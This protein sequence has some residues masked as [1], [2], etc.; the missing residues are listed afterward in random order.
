[1]AGS[2]SWAPQEHDETLAERDVEVR[3][4]A[5][6]AAALHDAARERPGDVA[7]PPFSHLGVRSC[8]SLRDGAIRPR[9]LAA[10]AAAAGMTHVALTDRD[11]LY[12]AVRFAQAAAAE[13]VTPVFG[14]DLALAPDAARPGWELS[15]AGRVRL[16]A[17]AARRSTVRSPAG[18]PRRARPGRGAAWLEDDAP[19]VTFLARTTQ[20]YG[21]LCAT[22]TAAHAFGRSDPH[23]PAEALATAASRDGV[24]ALLGVDSPVGR[25][26]ARGHLDAAEA[27]VRRWLEVFG[28][29]GVVLGVRDHRVAPGGRRVTGGRTGHDP[30]EPG[31]DVRIRR[32]L[33]LAARLQVRAAAVNDVRYLRPEDVAVAD[34]LRCIRQQVPLGRRH[35]GRTTADAWFTTPAEQHDRFRERPDLLTTAHELATACEVDLGVGGLHVPRLSGLSPEAAAGELHRRCWEGVA[36]RYDRITPRIRERLERELAMVDR[37]ALHDL[38]LAVAAVV[39]DI[40]ELGV[41]VACRGSAAGSLVCFALRISDVDP[42]AN[43]LAFERFMNPYRDELP[44]I[45]LDVESH[46]REDVYDLVMARYGEDRTACVAMLETFQARSAIREVGKVLGIPAEELGQIA[47]SFTHARAR[48]VRRAIDH[49]PE[50]DHSRLDAGQLTTLFDLVERIDG[51]PRHIA[52]HPCGI[53]LAD[54]TLTDRTPLERSAH[55]Y[56]M[57]QFDKDDVAAL[58][59]LKLDV[60]GVRMLSAM[61]HCLDLV[62]G[63]GDTPPT[64]EPAPG[65]PG[66]DAEGRLDLGA[67]PHGDP[68]TYALIRSTHSVGIFQ[69]E[70]PGQRE[71]LGR[72]QPDRFGDLVTEISLFRPGPVKAD[73]VTPYVAR[74]HG[75]QATV[76]AHPALEPVLRETHGVI[77]YH[78][79]VM[80]VLAALTGCDLAYADL[81][82]RQLSDDRKVPAIRGWVL[83][84]ARDRGVGTDDALRVWEQLASFASFGF[85]KAHA[86]AFAV[87][88][89]RSAFLKTHVFPEFMAGLLTHDPGM[90]PRRMILDECRLFGVAVL[91]ADVNRSHPHY[92]VE[93]V[94]R[95]LADH[96]LGLTPVF[97]AAAAG[98]APGVAAALPPGW[99]WPAGE[100]RPLP[101]TGRD[102]GEAGGGYRYGVRMGLQDVR[103]ITDAELTSLV[104]G[105]PF[106]SLTDLRSRGELSRPTTVALVDAGALDQLAGVGRRGGPSSRRA[107]TLAVEELWR[108]RGARRRTPARG[109]ASTAAPSEA[110]PATRPAPPP[111]EQT[112]FDLHADHEPQLP[113]D[114]D[115]DRVRA[116]LAVTGLDVS[117][118]VVSFYEP[119]LAAL[120]VTRACD[121]LRVPDQRRVRVAGVKVAVQSPAQRSGQRVVFLSLDDRT[122]TTQTTFFERNLGDC[123]WTVLHA[124]LLVAEGRVTRRGR[125]G[126]TVTGL[127]A[128]DLSRLWRAW[129]EGWLDAALEE[130]GTPAPHLQ[131]GTVRPAGLQASEFGRGSR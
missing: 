129:Q 102:A 112:A 109:G 85:C 60:L 5:E 75:E 126:A 106:T 115:A 99:T 23:L 87:P 66:R 128:W 41:L 82:R 103:G 46:R 105:R 37:L 11:G 51:F 42:V 76:Y 73:M 4:A 48:D 117:R 40:R 39:E 25:S 101:P 21:D 52:M 36:A 28:R 63:C 31:D 113:P 14:A 57:S 49:L 121:L 108:D 9:E 12:G 80:G 43:D 62:N 69:I 97:R 35:L 26:V 19:R 53:L 18:D 45:D 81:L 65:A 78:E 130:R 58:G 79:Q 27:E 83:A 30:D 119:L 59:L 111:A 70:S 71:L 17:D 10:A 74:R 96:L 55:G 123:A 100:E 32:T 54:T 67:V 77:V 50:L 61:R 72:L 89:E 6:A 38:F 91:P 34:V 1:V 56:S 122:G 15:R 16:P 8:Y 29:E 98:D 114:G 22:V 20:G 93:V 44:D 90:Y 120:E 125:R 104:D 84:R 2:R 33:E 92:G 3:R 118:H 107:L 7:T 88:T 64:R 47:T 110:R 131:V 68:D 13:G 24:V 94:D 86:A 95:G 116:E 127:R 124:W